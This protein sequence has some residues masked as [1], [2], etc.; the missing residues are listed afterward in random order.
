MKD[1]LRSPPSENKTMKKASMIAMTGTT[2]FYL[3]CGGF[4][5]AAFGEDTPGNL[6]A[7]FGLFSGRYYWLIN[8]ANA[9]IVIHLVGSYQVLLE[10]IFHLLTNLFETT[11]KA[12]SLLQIL[13]GFQSNIFCQHWEVDCGEVAKHPVYTHKSH[14]QTS[15]VSN[16]PNQPPEA[17]SPNNLCHI[18]N[19]YCSDLSLL[20]PS[21]WSDGRVDFLALNYI[22]SRGDVL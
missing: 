7:G 1:T 20:Q 17:L 12:A 16:F 2:F 8:I 5:Y 22:F 6:L 19:H 13:T 14:L 18:N 3:C 15:M 9:C 11:R 4:G 10:N 21:Y